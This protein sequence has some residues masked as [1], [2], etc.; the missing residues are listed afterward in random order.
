M[1]HGEFPLRNLAGGIYYLAFPPCW[2]KNT[3]R[4]LLRDLQLT[5]APD[6]Q[7]DARAIMAS[8]A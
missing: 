7:A 2:E 3:E 6:L 1:L 8:E 5:L 4:K